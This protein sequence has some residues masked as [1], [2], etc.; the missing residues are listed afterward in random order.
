MS[1]YFPL[2]INV[3]SNQLIP[4]KTPMVTNVLFSLSI[5]INGFLYILCCNLLEPFFS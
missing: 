3:Q 5:T 1:D 4:Y 2:F